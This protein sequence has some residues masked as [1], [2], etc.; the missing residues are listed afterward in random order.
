LSNLQPGAV[1]INTSRSGIWDER[2]IVELLQSR[3]IAA[4]ATDVIDNEQTSELRADSLL[5][6]YAQNHPQ[7]LITPHIAGATFESMNMT[8]VFIAEKLTKIIQNET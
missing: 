4:L 5:L 3:H 7:V 1:L 8:E 2:A 6:K